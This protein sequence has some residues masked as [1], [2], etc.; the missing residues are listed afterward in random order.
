MSFGLGHGRDLDDAP[1]IVGVSDLEL[2]VLPDEA[3]TNPAAGRTD[4][5]AWFPDPSRPL[6]VEIGSGKGTFLLEQAR[7]EPNTNYLGI[8]WAREFYLYAAD[9]VRRAGLKNVRMLRTD[10][11]E[12]LRW[13]C[14]D[15][16]VSVIHLYF[17]DPWPKKRHHKNRVV[18]DR[19]LGEVWR[20]LRIADGG[21]RIEGK[22]ADVSSNPQSAIP[23]PQSGE[24]RLVTDHDDLWDWCLEHF[25][26]WTAETG[27]APAWKN[28]PFEQLEFTPPTWVGDGQLIG[29]NYERKMCAAEGKTAHAAVLRKRV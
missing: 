20:V 14:P 27:P 5:R 22:R 16:I 24:L 10:A 4:P 6:E 17:S 21:L 18:Q 23:N 11:T 1:G 9:R 8:E 12:F 3:L 15:G 19:F 2:P 28:A 13:R 26:R 25:R 29:T 7:R